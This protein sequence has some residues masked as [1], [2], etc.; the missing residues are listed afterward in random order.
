MGSAWAAPECRSSRVVALDQRRVR[1]AAAVL[2]QLG[3]A[4]FI[5]H[6]TPTREV[7]TPRPAG[8]ATVELL[9]RPSLNPPSA[10]SA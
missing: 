9:R 8:A 6:P 2:N 5:P 3:L 1:T 10:P 7:W 4:H